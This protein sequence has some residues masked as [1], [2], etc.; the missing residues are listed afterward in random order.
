MNDAPA[1]AVAPA[2]PTKPSE[3]PELSAARW[4]PAID[5][6]TPG[7]DIPR[8]WRDSVADLPQYQWEWWRFHSNRILAESGQTGPEAIEAAELTA[9]DELQEIVARLTS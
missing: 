1:K 8:D 5:D 6:P 2:K 9:W 4:G 3:W 7:L